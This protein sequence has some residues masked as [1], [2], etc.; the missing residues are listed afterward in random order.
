MGRETSPVSLTDVLPILTLA[1]FLEHLYQLKLSKN[2]SGTRKTVAQK[3][4]KLNMQSRCTFYLNSSVLLRDL[5]VPLGPQSN[6][7][8][9]PGQ[10]C[11]GQHHQSFY[12]FTASTKL[13]SKVN[14]HGHLKKQVLKTFQMSKKTH[15]FA[16]RNG[17]KL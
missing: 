17:K 9:T 15:S 16:D 1:N 13:W 12:L 4:E 2:S 11:P 5:L 8:Q 10:Q 6:S 7:K 3:A 14:S